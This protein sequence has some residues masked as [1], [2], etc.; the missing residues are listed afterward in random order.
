MPIVDQ[1][2]SRVKWVK[3]GEKERGPHQG[4]CGA[5]GNVQVKSGDMK[6]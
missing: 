5:R 1:S 2:R 4:N 3:D 6:T